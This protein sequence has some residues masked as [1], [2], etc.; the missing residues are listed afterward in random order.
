MDTMK[1]PLC[2]FTTDDFGAL[3]WHWDAHNRERDMAERAASDAAKEE[4]D[5]K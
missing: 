1:C 3:I 5:G 2:Q 4:S